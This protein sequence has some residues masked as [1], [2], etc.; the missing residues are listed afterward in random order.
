MTL[1]TLF[2]LAIGVSLLYCVIPDAVN[3]E[4]LRRGVSGG[5]RCGVMVELGS[6][7][8]DAVWALIALAG[9]AVLMENKLVLVGLGLL[10]CALLVFL[11]W[12]SWKESKVKEMPR[13]KTGGCKNDFITG[14]LI[15]LSN[16]F[17]LAFWIGLGGSVVAIMASDPSTLHY[18]AFF[19]GF[20]VGALSWCIIFPSIVAGS[21]KYVD[22]KVYRSLN[23]ACAFFLVYLAIMLIWELAS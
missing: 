1:L 22:L 6:V 4:A 12:C 15:S 17:T 5:F 20:M 3:T 14:A 8:G 19:L 10:G 11:A 7:I 9:L 18:L 2:A 21:R 13:P 23:L 16:P